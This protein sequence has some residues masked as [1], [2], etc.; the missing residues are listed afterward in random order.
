M[1]VLQSEEKIGPELYE[2]INTVGYYFNNKLHNELLTANLSFSFS[3]DSKI[4]DNIWELIKKGVALGVINY[5]T[6][7]TNSEDIPN[8]KSGVFHLSYILAPH[9]RVLPRRGS[10]IALKTILASSKKNK[11]END[12]ETLSLF[13]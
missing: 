8:T 3:I 1:E 5:N 7:L 2:F 6:N 11:I 12:D 9:F 10:T 4:N 13:E